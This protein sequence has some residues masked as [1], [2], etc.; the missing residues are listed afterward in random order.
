MQVPGG[1]SGFGVRGALP[2]R[3]RT[4]PGTLTTWGPVLSWETTSFPQT[5]LFLLDFDSKE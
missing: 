2:G 5:A 4:K 3:L 1:T